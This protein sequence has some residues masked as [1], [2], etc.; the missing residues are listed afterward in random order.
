MTPE[1]SAAD[2]NA[3]CTRAFIRA[4]GMMTKNITEIGQGNTSLTYRE[5]D[6][7]S[8]IDQE[9]IGPNSVIIAMEEM[10]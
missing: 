4:M 5:E 1:Q 9:G 10:R 2:I 3:R 6:L 7:L 8:L